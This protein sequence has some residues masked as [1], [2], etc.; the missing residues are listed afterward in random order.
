MKLLRYTTS[1]PRPGT[2]LEVTGPM[3]EW[4]PG[5]PPKKM[6]SKKGLDLIGLKISRSRK[7]D[8]LIG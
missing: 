1:I 6:A 2:P 5:C 3:G 4:Q 7:K 8:R